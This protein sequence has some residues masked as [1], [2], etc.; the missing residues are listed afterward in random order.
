MAPDAPL[1]MVGWCIRGLV[2]TGQWRSSP[3]CA[4]IDPDPL[5]SARTNARLY[6][7]AHASA[8]PQSG[9][10][11]ASRTYTTHH[12]HTMSPTLRP[13]RL[14]GSFSESALGDAMRSLSAERALVNPPQPIRLSL[15]SL[16]ALVPDGCSGQPLGRAEQS[17]LGS[18]LCV[19]SGSLV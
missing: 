14:E 17:S 5:S 11:S 13:V 18:F 19:A 9:S 10:A 8:D 16:S 15:L 6:M 3:C 7:A 4:I 2:T 12:L 1:M